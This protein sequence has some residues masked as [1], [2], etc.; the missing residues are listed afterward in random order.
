MKK[1]ILILLLSS[2]LFAQEL[3]TKST[4]K[5]DFNVAFKSSNRD[6]TKFSGIKFPNVNI[7][8]IDGNL[9]TSKMSK[10]LV[11]YNFWHKGCAPC[12]TEMEMLNQLAS[13]FSNNVDF[14]GITFNSKKEINSFTKVHPFNFRHISLEQEKINNLFLHKGYPASFLV[15]DGEIIEYSSGGFSDFTSIYCYPSLFNTYSK[16]R[17]AIEDKLKVIKS[18]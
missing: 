10:R 9:F 5:F 2:T 3:T 1:N 4:D 8:D 17:N 14:V 16:F 13:L 7:D 11:F 6:A 12:I 18:E 15:F